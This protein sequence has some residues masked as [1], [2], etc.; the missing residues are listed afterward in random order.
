MT[1]FKVTNI[2]F[3]Y[4]LVAQKQRAYIYACSR[5]KSRLSMASCCRVVF[6]VLLQI[7]SNPISYPP[8]I[9]VS[10]NSKQAFATGMSQKSTNCVASSLAWCTLTVA[11]HSGDK[12][13]KLVLHFRISLLVHRWKQCIAVQCSS[14]DV[15]HT[16]SEEFDY[17]EMCNSSC[18]LR[19]KKGKATKSDERKKMN[20]IGHTR[21]EMGLYMLALE[22]RNHTAVHRCNTTAKKTTVGLHH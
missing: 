11:L 1:Q 4:S 9:S 10:Q 12:I 14:D 6:S 3:N 22:G 17:D 13:C 16:V 8:S 7:Y 18:T 21:H 5:L 2:I 15:A 19:T 20:E